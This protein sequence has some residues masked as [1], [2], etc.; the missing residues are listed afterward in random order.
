M[1]IT[2]IFLATILLVAT[3]LPLSATTLKEEF[4]YVSPRPGA[5]LVSKSTTL[6]FKPI[7]GTADLPGIVVTGSSSGTVVGDWIRSRDNKT[8]I[9]KPHRAFEPGERVSVTVAGLD[10]YSFRVAPKRSSLM[11]FVE[12]CE[13]EFHESQSP[14][15]NELAIRPRPAPPACVPARIPVS[16]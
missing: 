1:R 12:D 15:K 13:C 3:F 2:A 16:T 14:S 6:I 9:F 10:N 7:N 4:T 11:A 8:M 5:E